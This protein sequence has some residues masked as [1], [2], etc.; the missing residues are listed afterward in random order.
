MLNIFQNFLL[1][2]LNI[3]SLDDCIVVCISFSI[4]LPA[5]AMRSLVLYAGVAALL[6]GR[7]IHETVHDCGEWLQDD[8]TSQI[9]CTVAQFLVQI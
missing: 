3:L 8:G 9:C 7:P 2:N 6:A 5:G 1:P 4:P